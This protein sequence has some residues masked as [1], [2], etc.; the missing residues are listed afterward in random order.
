MLARYNR[1]VPFRACWLLCGIA[2]AAAAAAAEGVDEV[3]KQAIERHRAGDELSALRNPVQTC[4]SIVPVTIA[5]QIIEVRIAGL[6]LS[7]PIASVLRAHT[8]RTA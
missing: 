2:A 8:R 4:I 5:R 1:G 7:L 6:S 3:F